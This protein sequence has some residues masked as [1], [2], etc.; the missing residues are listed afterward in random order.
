MAFSPALEVLFVFCSRGR[1]KIKWLYWECNGLQSG[2]S[3]LR[4]GVSAD[5]GL[6]NLATLR[7]MAVN[8]LC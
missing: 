5:C 3:A 8:P 7:T 6:T 4:N 1:D 2:I